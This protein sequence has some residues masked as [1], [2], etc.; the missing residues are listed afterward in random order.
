MSGV[1]RPGLLA[2]FDIIDLAPP[3][4]DSL[5]DMDGD[6]LTFVYPVQPEWVAE[7]D[8][9]IRSAV[10]LNGVTV[11]FIDTGV[12]PSQTI[13]T[14]SETEVS[15]AVGRYYYNAQIEIAGGGT[16]PMGV[17]LVVD[18]PS[19]D[20]TQRAHIITTQDVANPG[21]LN[22]SPIYVP[23]TGQLRVTTNANGGIA[24][25]AEFRALGIQRRDQGPIPVIPGI[26]VSGG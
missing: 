20:G 3:D 4:R 9:A 5:P 13:T 19:Q 22:F 24:D 8:I 15:G 21:I 25:S 23:P 26:V 2:Y 11:T 10:S 1:Q 16:N 12:A 6:R 18:Y 14:D 7:Q 17:S